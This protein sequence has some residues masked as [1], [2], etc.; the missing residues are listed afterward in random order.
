MAVRFINC[1]LEVE[2][3][4]SL[5]HILAHFLG[6]KIHNLSYLKTERGCFANFEL[7]FYNYSDPNSIIVGF[8]DVIENLRDDARATWNDAYCRKLDLGYESDIALGF[9]RSEL[10]AETVRRAAA[11]GA[12]IVVT[13]YTRPVADLDMDCPPLEETNDGCTVR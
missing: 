3:P 2:G 12:S 10:K 8:C 4:R 11:L 6:T 7:S 13:I 5:E 1:D 9:V